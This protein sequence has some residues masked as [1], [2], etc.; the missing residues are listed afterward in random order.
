M[1]MGGTRQG[2][3]RPLGSEDRAGGRM[4]VNDLARRLQRLRDAGVIQGTSSAVL[5]ALMDKEYWLKIIGELEAQDDWRTLAELMKF[6]QQ[7]RDGRPAQQINVTSLGVTFNTSE[8]SRVKELV[9]EL[10]PELRVAHAN[11]QP[12]D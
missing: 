8:M 9:R 10:S 5:Y 2:A 6:H 12:P 4:T 3:G 11:P 7:M 1:A